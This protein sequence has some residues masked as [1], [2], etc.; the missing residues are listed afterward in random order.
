MGRRRAFTLIELLVVVA[1]IALLVGILLSSVHQVRHAAS[2]ISCRNNLRQIGIASHNCHDSI[3]RFPPGVVRNLPVMGGN[4][5]PPAPAPFNDIT[6]YGEYWPWTVFLLPYLEQQ[7]A[8]D[9]VDWLT[10]PWYQDIGATKMVVLLCAQDLRDNTTYMLAERELRAMSYQGIS[11]TN[12]FAY[13]GIFCVNRALKVSQIQDGASNTMMVGE[14]PPTQ[15]VWYGW[16]PGGMG[17][18]P[19]QGTADTIL[20]VADKMYTADAP[21]TFRPGTACDSTYTHIMHYWSFHAGGAN[22]LFADGSVRFF[23]Y[24]SNLSPLATYDGAEVLTE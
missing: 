1:I 21:E 9:R 24:G 2:R 20:G 12:Q 5:Q 8:Y 23:P 13:D 7:A 16:W 18:W 10:R 6:R 19:Y 15:N 11:G 14:R 4:P 22:F 17:V 3:G